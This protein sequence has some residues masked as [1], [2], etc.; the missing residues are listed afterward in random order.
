[1]GFPDWE[2]HGGSSGQTS[3]ALGPCSQQFLPGGVFL[4]SRDQL[5][6][7]RLFKQSRRLWASGKLK[8]LPFIAKKG[9]G[10]ALPRSLLELP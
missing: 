5:D 9:L 10:S 4:G 8:Q 7:A 1:M 6:F 3:G 2:G